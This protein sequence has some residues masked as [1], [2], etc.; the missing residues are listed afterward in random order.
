MKSVLTLMALHFA[1]FQAKAAAAVAYETREAP[2]LKKIGDTIDKIGT[3]FDEYKKTNDE[4]LN[5]LKAKGG[6]DPLIEAKLAKMDDALNTLSEMKSQ[7]EKVETKLARPGALGAGNGERAHQPRSRSLQDG[8]PVL[9]SQSF[10]PGTR[11]ALQ[12]RQKARQVEAKA[13]GGD[14][15]F[16]TRATQTV[17]SLARL[18]A[19]R[20][21]K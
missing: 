1:A 21:R 20:C 17:T 8:F 12:H 5:Q 4:R 2:D 16:E 14:D 3:A 7:L 18:A 13:N 9:G 6:V 10:G 11:T 15:G 19:S